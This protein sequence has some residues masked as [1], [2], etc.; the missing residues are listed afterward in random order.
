MGPAAPL[1]RQALVLRQVN[2]MAT[3]VSD[4]QHQ[5]RRLRVVEAELAVIGRPA[6]GVQKQGHVD[7]ERGWC[8]PGH[9]DGS[10]APD[11]GEADR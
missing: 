4:G 2:L 5:G 7:A 8:R 9:S 1:A 3:P 10:P 6:A 11:P